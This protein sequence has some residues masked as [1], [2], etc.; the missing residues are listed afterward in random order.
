MWD[1][2]GVI[3]YITNKMGEKAIALFGEIETPD[4]VVVILLFNACAQVETGEAVDL[5]KRVASQMP[6]SYGSNLSIVTSLL[7]ALM[8]CGDVISARSLFDAS[9]TKTLFMYGAMMKGTFSLH[10]SITCWMV[11][12]RQGI[13][14]TRWVTRRLIFS[15]K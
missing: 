11:F 3:G 2:C 5:V 7:N 6:K 13:S 14:R 9:T 4:E 12:L 8:K 15:M 1:K 10:V